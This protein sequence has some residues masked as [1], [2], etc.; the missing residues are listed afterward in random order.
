MSTMSLCFLIRE[1]FTSRSKLKSGTNILKASNVFAQKYHQID[2]KLEPTKKH[3]KIFAL[4]TI[5]LFSG[6]LNASLPMSFVG[7]SFA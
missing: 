3:H 6:S 7:N 5:F 2:D 4:S 1:Q